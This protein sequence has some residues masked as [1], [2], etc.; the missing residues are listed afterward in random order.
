MMEYRHSFF[1]FHMLMRS[2]SSHVRVPLIRISPL[3]KGAQGLSRGLTFGWRKKANN[4]IMDWSN[5]GFVLTWEKP[6][7]EPILQN[8][9]KSRD[10]ERKLCRWKQPFKFSKGTCFLRIFYNNFYLECSPQLS[11][12]LWIYIN[13]IVEL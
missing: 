13:M 1:V 2:I 5:F 4:T 8:R 11:T 7:F 9:N 6:R 3:W 10:Q 12:L